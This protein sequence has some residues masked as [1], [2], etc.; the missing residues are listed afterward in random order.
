MKCV[1]TLCASHGLHRCAPLL[2]TAAV[3]CGAAP[4]GRSFKNP[5]FTRVHTLPSPNL[6]L[7]D[8]LTRSFCSSSAARR[9]WSCGSAAQLFFCSACKAIQPPSEEATYFEIL[10]CDQ[11][12]A[13]DIQ[14][15]QR[16]F[17]ELQRSLHPDNFSLKSSTEQGY[18]EKQSALVNKAFRTLQKPVTRAVYMLQLHGIEL[19]EGTDATAD[20][21]FLLE[22]MEINEKLAES[23]SR[24]EVDAIG[25]AVRETLKVL[26]EQMNTSLNKGNLQSAKELL[27]RMKYFT[28]LEEKVKEKLTENL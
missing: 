12:F 9:C 22:V 11:T 15:L 19:E 20:S 10:N 28:N 26:T 6:H 18:S 7:Q 24:E 21:S 5:D 14:K 13:L 3:R 27:A 1:R 23:R 8:S 16:R 25:Q 17:I 2:R 4:A